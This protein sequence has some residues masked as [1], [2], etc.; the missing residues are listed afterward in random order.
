MASDGVVMPFT[1]TG[2]LTPCLIASTADQLIDVGVAGR[3]PF[4]ECDAPTVITI[5]LAPALIA[6]CTCDLRGGIG[7]IDLVPEGGLG[8]SGNLRERNARAA[9]HNHQRFSR[10]GAFGGRQLRVGMEAFLIRDWRDDDRR[11]VFFTKEGD[12]QIHIGRRNVH[13]RP[14]RDTIEQR[15]IAARDQ[16]KGGGLQLLFCFFL[17]LEQ[18][19]ELLTRCQSNRHRW[20]PRRALLVAERPALVPQSAEPATV[21][22]TT[23]PTLPSAFRLLTLGVRLKPDSTIMLAHS[24][25]PS[26]DEIGFDRCLID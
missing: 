9:A 26:L 5:A 8:D 15:S 11:E 23:A 20:F 18:I 10:G 19:D 7:R 2:R 4:A 13:P 16:R 12:A 24:N 17:E 21:P 14:K 25:I 3:A 6:S 1:M 22:A